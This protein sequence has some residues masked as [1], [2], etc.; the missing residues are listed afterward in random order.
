[1]SDFKVTSVFK[2]NILAYKAGIKLIINQGGTRSSKSWSILQLLYLIADSSK[3]KLIISIV[4]RALPHL[5]MGVMRDFDN[6]LISAGIIPDKVKNISN[7]FYTIGNC[8]IEFFG[9]DQLDKV[10]GPGRDILFINEANFLKQDVYDHLAIRTTGVIFID[11]NPTQQ[12]W[13][14]DQVM[15]TSKHILIKSTYLDNEFLPKIQIQRIEAKKFNFNWWQVYGLGEV[16]RLEGA[17]FSN[18]EYGEFDTH[19][20][21]IFGLDFGYFPDP[22]ALVKVAINEKIKTIYIKECFYNNSQGTEELTGEIKKHCQRNDLIISDIQK[23]T[24]HD[25]KRLGYN[26]R[27]V[28]KTK[29]VSDWLRSM[30]DYKIIITPDSKNAEKELL[31]YIWSDKKAGIPLD[32]YNHILDAAR[33]CFIELTQK[34]IVM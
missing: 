34:R 21:P 3:E 9:A 20:K 32:G 16:G 10:H 5:K 14:H 33:Y 31:N 25:I 12:F 7:N 19:I 18:W 23:R 24:I 28:R 8:I 30:Q 22:D 11:F 15:P 1:M 6:I 4:S 27:Q 29:T 26:I 2:K 13:V 17:I